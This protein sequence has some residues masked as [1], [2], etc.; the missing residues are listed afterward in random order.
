MAIFYSVNR[1]KILKIYLCYLFRQRCSIHWVILETALTT[2]TGLKLGARDFFQVFH[3]G[4]DPRSWAL[5][6]CFPRP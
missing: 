1:K 6:P 5:F 4:A 2:K 3:V